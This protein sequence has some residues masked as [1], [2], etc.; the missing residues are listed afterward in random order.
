VEEVVEPC[1]PLGEIPLLVTLLFESSLS[2]I[3]T[4]S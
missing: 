4:S 2:K 1:T 3:F